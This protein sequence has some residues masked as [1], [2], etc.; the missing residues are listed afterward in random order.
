M[1]F[2]AYFSRQARKPNGLFGRFFMSRVFEKGNAELNDFVF[3][4]L[5]V[6]SDD[7]ILEVGFGTGVLITRVAQRLDHGLI[8]GV[9]FSAIMVAL[10]QKKNK[11]ALRA[12][13]ARL[14]LGDFNDVPFEDSRFNAVFTVNTIYFWRDPATTIARIGHVLKPGGKCLI[15]FNERSD[16]EKMNLDGDVFSLYAPDE[17][18]ALLSANGQ[19]AHVEIQSRRTQKGSCYCA[20]ALK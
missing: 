14:H 17:I 10:A 12:G 4:Q 6:Q 13:K 11:L 15:G 2:S 16:L 9:D 8:E 7:H 3:E 5:S 1:N 18:E 19:F 20:V